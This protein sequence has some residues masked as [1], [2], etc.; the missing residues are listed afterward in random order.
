MLDS[1]D[2][3]ETRTLPPGRDRDGTQVESE[4]ATGDDTRAFLSPPTR[5]DALGR[6]RHYELLAVLGRGGFGTVYRA[7]D[8]KLHRVVALKVLAPQLAASGSA[9]ARFLWEVRSAA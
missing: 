9:R 8:E 4:P 7:F 3:G 1:A 2:G 6:L 5:P